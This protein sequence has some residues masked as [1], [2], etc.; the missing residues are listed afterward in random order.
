MTLFS[1]DS[2]SMPRVWTGKEDIKAITLLARSSVLYFSE[3]TFLYLLFFFV[4][5]ES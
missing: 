2:D 4:L 1:H 5:G 3:S